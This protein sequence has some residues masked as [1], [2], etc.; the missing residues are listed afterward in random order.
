MELRFTLLVL[1]VQAAQLARLARGALDCRLFRLGFGQRGVS[2][3]PVVRVVLRARLVRRVARQ[4]QLNVGHRRQRQ[5]VGVSEVLHLLVKRGLRLPRRCVC[6][7]GVRHELRLLD[8]GLRL[9]LAGDVDLILEQRRAQLDAFEGV[10]GKRIFLGV[11]EAVVLEPVPALMLIF[12]ATCEFAVVSPAV[13]VIAPPSRVDPE[14]TLRIN[15]PPFPLVAEPVATLIKPLVPELV[16]PLEKINDPE[17]PVV[18]ALTVCNTTEPLL[19]D[20]PTPVLILI[21]PPVS[22]VLVPADDIISPPAVVAPVPIDKIM[23][24]A[25]PPA[26]FPVEIFAKPEAPELVVPV[27]KERPPLTPSV[28]ASYVLTTT[29]PLVFVDP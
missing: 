24:P 10:D 1:F 19:V 15:D 25:F 7:V 20:V 9:E 13:I 12:P 26:A 11:F 27:E 3:G 17:I 8:Q 4:R 29:P 28:P 16:V 2:V 23:S 22:G 5:V 6:D 14:P 21:E 18:P